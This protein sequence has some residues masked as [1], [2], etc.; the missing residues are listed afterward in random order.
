MRGSTCFS[1]V[2]VS[3]LLAMLLAGTATAQHVIV[4]NGSAVSGYYHDGHSGA[5]IAYGWGRPRPVVRYRYYGYVPSYYG[6]YWGSSYRLGYRHG[7]RDGWWDGRRYGEGDDDDDRRW[8]RREI[9]Y[10]MGLY[11][12]LPLPGTIYFNRPVRTIEW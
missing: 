8:R 11:N 7:Y 2:G 10:D 6:G 9:Y 5:Y 1:A 12:G 3:V 4:R